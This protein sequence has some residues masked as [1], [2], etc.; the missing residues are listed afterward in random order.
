MD[1]PQPPFMCLVEPAVISGCSSSCKPSCIRVPLCIYFTLLQQ[2]NII[3]DRRRPQI[4][5]CSFTRTPG[6]VTGNR[7][8]KFNIFSWKAP[9]NVFLLLLLKDACCWADSTHRP[10]HCTAN[11]SVRVYT[12][13]AKIKTY[14]ESFWLESFWLWWIPS[15]GLARPEGAFRLLYLITTHHIQSPSKTI[16]VCC[17]LFPGILK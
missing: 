3:S 16:H 8:K 14:L 7:A 9:G 13:V 1:R 12:L 17:S 15:P 11:D 2:R 5:Y 4:F 6:C 10:C